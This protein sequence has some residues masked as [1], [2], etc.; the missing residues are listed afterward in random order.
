MLLFIQQRVQ[1]PL[2][3]FIGR[4]HF[5]FLWII[6]PYVL[7]VFLLRDLFLPIYQRFVDITGLVPYHGNCSF[8]P[9]CPH[10]LIWLIFFGH[11]ELCHVISFTCLFH[12]LL[13][14]WWVVFYPLLWNV[15]PCVYQIPLTLGSPS[16]TFILFNFLFTH[17]IC[18]HQTILIIVILH[19]KI[20]LTSP[21]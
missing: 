16:G 8:F 2:H 15:T 20:R 13:L 10:L 18:Q 3:I 5:F 4:L 7:S 21:S 1:I 11:R 6:S 9:I 12:I 14:T 19:F 17:L